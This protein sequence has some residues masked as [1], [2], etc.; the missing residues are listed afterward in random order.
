[1][2]PKHLSR[3]ILSFYNTLLKDELE[4]DIIDVYQIPVPKLKMILL[5]DKKELYRPEIFRLLEK[6]RS[7]NRI[8]QILGVT[9]H[10]VR[11][12]ARK[13]SNQRN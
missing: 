8:C 11:I 10:T 7:W 4:K 6:G 5:Y 1:M 12:V 9:Y 2:T 13:R 3:S